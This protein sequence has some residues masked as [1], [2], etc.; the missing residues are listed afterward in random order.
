MANDIAFQALRGGPV[1]LTMAAEIA[2]NV[3]SLQSGLKNL[4][5]KMGHLQC[6]TGCDVFHLGMERQFVVNSINELNPQ[7]LPPGPLDKFGLPQDPVPIVNVLVPTEVMNDIGAINK[8]AADVLG[9]LGCAAC[10]SGFDIA[11]RRQLDDFRVDGKLNVE[12]VANFR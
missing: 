8:V 7:P 5:E 11:F 12:R 4:A 10:C 9:K 2:N 3:D 6:F 1:R